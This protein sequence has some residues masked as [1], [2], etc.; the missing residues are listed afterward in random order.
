MAVSNESGVFGALREHSLHGAADQKGQQK[1]HAVSVLGK[2][3]IMCIPEHL[4]LSGYWMFF[5]SGILKI[6]VSFNTSKSNN[7]W[8]EL[9][10]HKIPTGCAQ[11]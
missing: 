8:L 9:E 3:W 5:F 1:L 10:D 11:N 7:A 2:G 6:Y 4:K